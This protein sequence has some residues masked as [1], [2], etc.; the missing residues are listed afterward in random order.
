MHSLL[1]C[2]RQATALWLRIPLAS[3]V[4]GDLVDGDGSIIQVNDKK[5]TNTLRLKL[6]FTDTQM[7]DSNG[8]SWFTLYNGDVR[9]FIC[10]TCVSHWLNYNIHFIPDDLVDMPMNYSLHLVSCYDCNSFS[11]LSNCILQKTGRRQPQRHPLANSRSNT[12]AELFTEIGLR[13]WDNWQATSNCRAAST[14]SRQWRTAS[15]MACLYALYNSNG[16]PYCFKTASTIAPLQPMQ[17]QKLCQEQPLNH[18]H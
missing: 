8:S 11:T 9:Y 7:L 5:L 17:N 3:Q 6:K 4:I 2:M 13:F 10:S 16:V 12:L 18:F 1:W 14:G 15:C